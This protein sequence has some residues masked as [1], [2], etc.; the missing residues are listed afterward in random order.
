MFS[1]SG[2][3]ENGKPVCISS[4]SGPIHV[5]NVGTRSVEGCLSKPVT[6]SYAFQ[7]CIHFFQLV[8]RFPLVSNFWGSDTLAINLYFGGLITEGA[9]A[10]SGMSVDSKWWRVE[11]QSSLN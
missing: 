9:S 2:S 8:A 4:A 11:A 7:T 10:S 3:D 6:I 5:I 1:L